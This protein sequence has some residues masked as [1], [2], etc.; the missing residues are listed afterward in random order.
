MKKRK[1]NIGFLMIFSFFLVLLS[2][3]NNSFDGKYIVESTMITVT[4]DSEDKINYHND[5]LNKKYIIQNN[6]FIYSDSICNN[7]SKALIKLQYINI[8][9]L[10]EKHSGKFIT[11]IKDNYKLR[12]VFNNENEEIEIYKRLD[13]KLII[14]QDP[15]LMVLRNE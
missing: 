1:N 14:Y 2:C 8:G 10:E 11:L 13:G 5:C 4:S 3:K 6:K 15:Y 7:F 9:I 12:G